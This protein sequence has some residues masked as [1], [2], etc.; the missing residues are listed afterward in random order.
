MGFWEAG[1]GALTHHV[2]LD[3]SRIANYQIITPSTWMASPQDSFGVPGPYGGSHAYALA[4]GVRPRRQLYW[5]RHFTDN[6]EL[7]SLYALYRAHGCR[8]TPAPAQCHHVHVRRGG[9]GYRAPPW[10]RPQESIKAARWMSR[11]RQGCVPMTTADLISHRCILVIDD[12][13]SICDDFRKILQGNPKVS[14]LHEAR[15]AL[16]EDPPGVPLD[17]S[18]EGFEV[19]CADQGETGLTMV[20]NA[21][22]RGSPYAVAFV[23]MLMPPGWDCATMA[24]VWTR[25]MPGV[26]LDSSSGCIR[27]RNIPARGWGWRS[28]RRLLNVTAAASG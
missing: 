7:R 15:A 23:D 24:S 12:N 8:W 6:S 3:N 13:A 22:Q 1:R 25:P 17:E 16:F 19:D 2:V 28:A 4:G 20:Q 21:L 27:V 10:R 5:H 14:S 18:Q 11:H 26:S 9:V